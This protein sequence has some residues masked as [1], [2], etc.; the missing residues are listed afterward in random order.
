L[1]DGGIGSCVLFARF[2]AQ[3]KLVSF[4]GSCIAACLSIQMK[5]K[6]K[7]KKRAISMGLQKIFD[8]F[9]VLVGK[10]CVVCSSL[11]SALLVFTTQSIYF[12]RAKLRE[13]L[14]FSSAR[15]VARKLDFVEEEEEEKLKIKGKCK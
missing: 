10:R 2:I 3:N 13:K 6:L 1:L 14:F 4:I 15:E 9:R 8:N 11:R 5:M 12:G 7:K